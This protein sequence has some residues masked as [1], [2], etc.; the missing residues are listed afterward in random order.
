MSQPWPTTPLAAAQRAFDLMVCPPTHVA[1]DGRGLAGLPQRIL[2]LDELKAFLIADATPRRVRDVAW[3]DLV[4]RARRDGPAW[5]VAAVGI[6]MPGLRK[7]AGLLS[8]GRRGD[9]VDADADLLEGFLGRLRTIDL[10]ATRICGR[11][12]DAGARAVK[13]ARARDADNDAILVDA[14]WSLP[15]SQPW[16]HPDWVLA[17]AVAA[18]VIDPEEHLLIAETRLDDTPLRQV[19]DQLHISVPLA[20]AWRRRAELRL[21]EAVRDGEL[22]WVPLVSHRQ[23]A[24]AAIAVMAGR[25]PASTPDGLGRKSEFGSLVSEGEIAAADRRR[26]SRL[27]A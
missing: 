23:Q 8:V 21:L 19:A 16:D 11:L 12:I 17:R 9:S 1:F 14:A 4:V 13:R 3:R 6:A 5:V 20:A 24:S 26:R 7:M 22:E 10:D 2:G 25:W 15:P 18:A 27:T